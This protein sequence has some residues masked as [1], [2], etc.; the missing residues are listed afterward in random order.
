MFKHIAGIDFDF[1]HQ[2]ADT[3]EHVPARR[4]ETLALAKEW[5]SGQAI[6]KSENRAA[7]HMVLRSVSDTTFPSEFTAPVFTERKKQEAFVRACTAKHILHIGIG[8]SDL[9]PRLVIDALQGQIPAQRRVTFLSSLTPEAIERAASSLNP[10]ESIVIIASKSFT[11]DET[12]YL[13]QTLT[14]A[15][16]WPID[17]VIAATANPKKAIEAGISEDRIFPF[18]DWVG[19]RYSLWSSVGLPIALTYGWDAFELLLNGAAQ[20]DA[21]LMEDVSESVGFAMAKIWNTQRVKNARPALAILPYHADLALLPNW[22]QQLVMESNGKPS[23]EPSAPIVFGAPGTEFQ[24]SFGQ[25]LHQGPD[26]CT[27]I[28]LTVANK[29]GTEWARLAQA[30]LHANARA[31]AEV[32]WHGRTHDDPARVLPGGRPSVFI[33]LPDL[34]P[35][36]LGVLLATFE[37]AAVLDGFMSGVNPFDQWG[38][39]AGKLMAQKR[40]NGGA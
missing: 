35:F 13:L 2:S 17:R 24:H 12:S 31:Q 22:M 8:G 9:G 28:F 6:N 4:D 18:W 16:K 15:F 11:T 1:T 36:S 30:R 25:F 19:G 37:H 21:D 3:L 33:S 7:M 5:L 39:E 26:L 14:G 27:A 20:S 10:L 34:T 29:Y 40:L 23:S 38:V 32:L